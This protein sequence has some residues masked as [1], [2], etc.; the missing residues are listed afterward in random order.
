MR[1]EDVQLLER[2]L[3][4]LLRRARGTWGQL[5]REVHPDLEPAA[6][7]I[8]ARIADAGDARLTDLAAWFGVGKPTMSRQVSQLE[9]LELIERTPDPDDARAQRVGLTAEGAERVS[10]ARRARNAHFRERLAAWPASDVRALA[11]LLHRLNA[12]AD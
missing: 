9:R 3:G 7:G 5:A 8:L 2:E 11:D 6:Y 4:V 12:T 10:R 1:E